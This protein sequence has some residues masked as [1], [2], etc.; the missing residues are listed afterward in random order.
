MHFALARRT[1]WMIRN[2]LFIQCVLSVARAMLL[3]PFV[4]SADEILTEAK[5]LSV[6]ISPVHGRIVADLQGGIW[7]MPGNG[8][9]ADLLTDAEFRLS[10]PRWSPD[11]RRILFRSESPSGSSLWIAQFA[12]RESGPINAAEEGLRDGAWHPG[13]DSI[14]FAAERDDTGLDIWEQD[15]PTGLTWKLTSDAGDEFEPAWSANG[16]HLAYVAFRD[17]QYALMLR[18]FGLPAVS[19]V[20]SDTPLS[21]PS[22]RPDGSLLTFQ[23]HDADGTRLEMAILSEPVLIREVETREILSR[24]PVSW[25][26]RMQM[27]YGADGKIRQ[28]GFEDRRSTPVHFRAILASPP[29]IAPPVIVQRQIDI[30]NPPDNRLIIRA[31]RMFDGIG[32]FYREN[33]D[34]VIQNGR[35]ES[36]GEVRQ[37]DNGTVL[38]LGDV[39][40]MPGMIDALVSLDDSLAAGATLLAYGVTTVVADNE[41]LSFDHLAWEGE[42]SP[43]PRILMKTMPDSS[44][45][46]ATVLSGIADMATPG[47]TALFESRQA[48][49]LGQTNRSGRQSA[50]PRRSG[51]SLAQIAASSRENLMPT[52]MGLHAELRA[53]AA[54]GLT[55]AQVLQATGKNA[56]RLLGLENQVGVILPGAAADLVLINGDPLD[57]V[58]DAINVLA[59]VRNGRF[60]SLVTLME[61]ANGGKGVE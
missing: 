56:A 6:D 29:P 8:G 35:I 36:V 44:P 15:L 53:L 42:D 24:A 9:Q 2:R 11:G 27:L 48:M 54:S 21:S 5:D 41:K 3:L 26:D 46:P 16:R 57:D 7:T 20:I 51:T 30:V 39:T 34:I 55:G 60:F 25:R 32:S 59:V 13:G 49:V 18:R 61:Q 45:L 31:A 33:V 50:G 47:V 40:V 28:R 14:V 37:Y 1:L 38:D 4:A 10:Q 23:R 17:G 43:G 52:G 19:L 22:W 12:A 58:G